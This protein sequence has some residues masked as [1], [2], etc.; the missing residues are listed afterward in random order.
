MAEIDEKSLEERRDRKVVAQQAALIEKRKSRRQFL[1]VVIGGV[2]VLSLTS[3]AALHFE[4]V[5][6]PSDK[7]NTTPAIK[8]PYRE[9]DTFSSHAEQSRRHA[10]RLWERRAKQ[11]MP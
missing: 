2:V 11:G 3:A 10:D 1:M 5:K 4:V 8:S 7:A 9:A 6:L